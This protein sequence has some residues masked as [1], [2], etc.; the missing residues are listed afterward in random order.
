MK[1]TFMSLLHQKGADRDTQFDSLRKSFHKMMAEIADVEVGDFV[2][3]ERA[4]D[5][6]V[7]AVNYSF[8]CARD[9]ET[10]R[11]H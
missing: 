8:F 2:S 6:I 7:K 3:I 4:L 1:A 10:C 5:P 11:N 9:V